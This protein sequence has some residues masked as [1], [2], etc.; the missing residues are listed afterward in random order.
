MSYTKFVEKKRE[1]K[2]ILMIGECKMFRE[3]I[4]ASLD[5]N[6]LLAI[7]YIFRTQL[8]KHKEC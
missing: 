1:K 6:T 5:T 4:D 2:I 7:L 8:D 3:W